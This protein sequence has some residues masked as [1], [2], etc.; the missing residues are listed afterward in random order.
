MEDYDTFVQHRLHQM[1]RN[2]EGHD[3]PSPASSAIRFCGQQILPPLLSG[4]QRE[5]MQRHRDAAQK[6]APRRKLKDD[7]RMAHVQAILHSVQ[8]R[9]TPTLEELLQES[10]TEAKS[11]YS[12]P[13]SGGSPS[14]GS[15]FIGSKDSLL[16]SPPPERK[17]GD[18]ASL[19]PLTSTT[20]S[21][22]YASNMTPQQNYQE[23]CLADRHYSQQ[24]SPPRSRNGVSQSVSSSYVTYETVENTI[25][26]SGGTDAGRESQAFGSPVGTHNMG[27]FFLHNTSN[28]I[29]KMPD[30]ISHPPIDGEELERSGLESSFSNNFIEIRDICCSLTRED[31]VVC[32]D[33]P[34]EPAES[35]HVDSTQGGDNLPVTTALDR[36]K[37]NPLDRTEG[38]VP[39]SENSGLSDNPE[40]SQTLSPHHCLGAETHIQHGPTETAPAHNRVDD[41]EL[42]EE[43]YR[44]S[45]QALLKKSQEYRRRQRM[46]RNQAKN[47]KIQERT[48]EQSRTRTEE[49]SL[50]DKENDEFP[51]K[52][53]VTA[54]G[55]K[56]KERRGTSIPS[57]ETSL[58]KSLENENEFFMKRP[59]F[60]SESA[61]LRGDGNTKEM[62]CDEE[63]TTFKNNKRNIS[64]MV[65]TEPKQQHML[66]ETSPVQEAFYLTTCPAALQKGTGKY[67]NIPEP[68]FCRSPVHCKSK[69]S[70]KDGEDV[71]GAETS[72]RKVLVSIALNED[73]KVEEVNPG[74]QNS[75]LVG[76]PT[77]NPVV[78]GN[79]TSVS[80]KSSLHIDQLESN[81]SSLKEL[82]SD[83]ESTLTKNLGNRGRTESNTQS[84][85]SFEGADCPEQIKNEQHAQLRQSRREDEDSSD[86]E[87]D[88]RCAEPLSRQSPDHFNNMHEHT[89]AEPSVSDTQDAVTVQEKGTEAVNV[90]ELRLVKT[91][92]T[93][94]GKE[95]GTCVEGL[96]KSYGQYG[97]CRKQQPPAKCV[98]SV[99]QRL[100]IPD[101]FRN[102]PPESTAPQVSSGFS[103]TSNHPVESRTEI[104]VE[105]Q[106]S[107]HLPSLNQSYDVDAP[108]GLWLLESSGSDLGARD[109][110]VQEKHL[111]PDSG[112][113]GQGEVSKV[114][115]RL[116]MHMTEEM[117]E[118]SADGSVV[119]PDS[120]TPRAAVR[121]HG[122]HCSETD[123]QEQLKQAHAA[124]VRAL[125]DEHR[126]QQEELL[127]ALAA[128][129]RLLQSVSFPCSMSSSRLGDTLTFSPLSQTSGALS[130]HYRPLLLAA[131]KGFLTR[132]L[133]RT[134]R[135]AQLV[136]TIRDTQQF[137]QALQQQSPARGEFISRQD[138]LLQERV[139]LQL[140]AAR[141]EVNDIFFSLSAAER[142]QL[143]SWDRELARERELRRQSGHTG[144]PKGRSSLS[145][146]TQKSLERKRGVMIQK[147]AAGR[148]RGAVKRSGLSAGFS[149]ERPLETKQGQ[150]RFNPQ[151][152]PKSTYSSRPR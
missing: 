91:L 31:S 89:E 111:T 125:Q 28:T 48:Q 151:G 117:W 87:R 76:P 1:R 34:V 54:E 113:E 35:S 128:R 24:G 37:D 30:I 148:N 135:V 61:H 70:I 115:R 23:G 129:Y 116:L 41:A 21:A 45:L 20:Y 131:V 123:K 33:S 130:E 122:G 8:L 83:L 79:V 12:Q 64:Q 102:D 105:G 42:S 94:R 40:F 74:D 109:H 43:P 73:R 143:I 141:Y 96:T 108:S 107:S 110:R 127:Q 136:R 32:E 29:A 142:M 81:L 120:S 95:K 51:H 6:S 13:T 27:V 104:A 9:K 82:I 44:L 134:E 68:N 112:S 52:G 90:S 124:Q 121:W 140:R 80:A 144:H 17:D 85:L 106:D 146:A 62:S 99:A 50:S 152:V 60:K 16:L 2:E 36:E 26:V 53:T 72:D 65:I 138:L 4:E 93:E 98:L 103:D 71:D 88:Q 100:R 25:S 149:A 126:R 22:F 58:K 39:S 78:E 67:H 55:K 38:P 92:A 114:K 133:L 147:R 145:A 119:R 57:V 7:A 5:E 118:R 11:S 49:Q 19:P 150:L 101:V 137:L 56:T 84:E 10:E 63:R 77:M 132:R 59:C 15:Y 46:L 139:T 86:A 66:T 69:G 97:G 75:L 47:T 3:D 14:Q 18:G